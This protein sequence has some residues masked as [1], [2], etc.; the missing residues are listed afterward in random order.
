M[1]VGL[2][3]TRAAAAAAAPAAS[4]PVPAPSPP[5]SLSTRAALAPSLARSAPPACPRLAPHPSC[6][7]LPALRRATQGQVPQQAVAGG[8]GRGAAPGGQRRGGA[9][10]DRRGHQPVSRRPRQPQPHG[11]TAPAPAPL[12]AAPR[13]PTAA[14]PTATGY[15]APCFAPLPPPCPAARRYGMDRRDGKDLAQL[16]RELGQLEGLRWIR[17]LCEWGQPSA[18]ARATRACGPGRLQPQRGWPAGRRA[19]MGACACNEAAWDG[20]PAAPQQSVAL[21]QLPHSTQRF[22]PCLR[23]RRRPCRLLPI[24]LQRGPYR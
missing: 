20:W 6:P 9:Q 8:A 5:G 1:H 16:L 13:R 17:L 14:Q 2:A 12:R 4:R 18:P 23:M 7:S 10:P 19:C 15:P 21:A 3:A 22:P 24:L 11:G